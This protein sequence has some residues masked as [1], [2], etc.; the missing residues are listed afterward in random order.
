MKGR[1]KD[2]REGWRGKSGDG[3]EP[4]RQEEREGGGEGGSRVRVTDGGRY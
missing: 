1:A 4:A 3:T 2:G